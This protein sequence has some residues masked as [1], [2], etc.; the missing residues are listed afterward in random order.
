MMKRILILGANGFIAHHIVKYFLEFTDFEIYAHYRSSSSNIPNSP[1]IY[2]FQMDLNE[3]FPSL[4]KFDYI[5]H[6]A[7]NTWV[8]GSLK[9]SIPYIKDNVLAT[10]NLLEWIK[11]NQS[12]AKICIFSSDEVLGPAKENEFFEEDAPL[13]PSSPYSASKGCQEILAYSFAH[14]FDLDIFIIRCMNVIGEGEKE[15]KFI[16]KTIKAIKEGKKITLHG[17]SMYDVASRHWIYAQDVAN[18][19]FFLL[20]KAESKEIYHIAGEE[21]DVYTL[22]SKIFYEI[23]NRKMTEKDVE[24]IDFHK[25][26]PGHDKR[27]SLSNK[28]LKTMGWNIKT[29]LNEVIKKLI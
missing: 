27:Y 4:P 9:D 6:T 1:K 14:A 18:A 7:A 20:E 5:V 28:K 11:N 26:R 8:D 16:G 10:A 2:L 24:F 22:A 3:Q 25:A 17:T 23:N 13:K 21:M 19:I 12:Q 15:N 29:P